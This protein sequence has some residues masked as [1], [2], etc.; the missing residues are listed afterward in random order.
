MSDK[1]L[2]HIDWYNLCG[3]NKNVEWN[4][5]IP[6]DVMWWDDGKILLCQMSSACKWIQTLENGTRAAQESWR[7]IFCFRI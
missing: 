5:E 7:W 3:E 6:W 2:K 1:L 4:S